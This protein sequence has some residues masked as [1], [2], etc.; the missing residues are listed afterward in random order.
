MYLAAFYQDKY[1]AAGSP[2]ADQPPRPLY[3][4][5]YPYW[6][7]AY[8]AAAAGKDED[9]QFVPCMA[10]PTAL[11]PTLPGHNSPLD[12]A[13]EAFRTAVVRLYNNFGVTD[14]VALLTAQT[15][16]NDAGVSAEDK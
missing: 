6:F 10:N 16:F 1:R 15:W 3:P 14:P 11:Y 13:R 2:T 12:K 8:N 7:V 4:T 5:N 9:W